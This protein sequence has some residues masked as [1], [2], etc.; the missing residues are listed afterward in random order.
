MAGVTVRARANPAGVAELVGPSGSVGRWFAGLI[1]QIEGVAQ[2]GCPVDTGNL[3]RSHDHSVTNLGFRLHGVVRAN[4]NYA[5]MVHQGTAP[6]EIRP[7]RARA[8]RFTV[9]GDVVFATRVMHPGTQG[10]PWLRTALVAVI[11]RV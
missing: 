9:G 8:L 10:Q 11:G 7:V 4:A 3:R 2:Q 1:R 6:H 5:L